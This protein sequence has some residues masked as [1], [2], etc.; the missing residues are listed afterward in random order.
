MEFEKKALDMYGEVIINKSLVQKA[1]FSARS[2]PTYVGEWI[3]FN[4]IEDGILT[5][6]SRVKVSNFIDRFLPQKGE[7]EEVKNRLINMEPVKLLDDYSVSINLQSGTRYLRIPFLDINDAIVSQKIIEDNNLLLGSG[8]WGVGELFYVPPENEK[9][10]GSVLMR[11]FKPFQI[12]AVDIDYFI[13][14]RKHFG[15]DEWLDLIISSMG[16]NPTIYSLEQKFVLITRIVAFVEPRINLI[17]LAPKGTGKSFVYDNF[18]RYARVVR[19]G[20]ITPAVMFF[21]HVRNTPGLISKYDTVVLDEIQSIQT[22]SELSAGLKTYLESGKFSRGDTEATSEA[23]FVMLGN[24]P[25]DKNRNPLNLDK[26]LLKDFPNFLQETAFLDRLHGI[27]PGWYMP[28][29]TSETPSQM[30]GFKGDFL[31]EVLHV[32]RGRSDFSDYVAGNMKLKNCKD[33]RDTK[34]I[35]RLA[36]G[37]LKILF[38]DIS[39]TKK[40]FLEYC[41]KP[42]IELRQRVRDE[43]HKMDPEYKKIKIGYE[44]DY[45]NND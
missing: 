13:E 35:Q 20:K 22:D 43:L 8:V 37:F 38:P 1:G 18:S 36:T 25:L 32:L 4:F 11:N 26:G 23:G 9:D 42:A 30:M 17:E 24:I 7:K 44:E 31:S 10:K 6:E 2:I 5:N 41:L 45:Y 40:E 19:G 21:H 33:L 29:V 34:A 28:R 12:G 27:I 15:L 39:L 14:C 3:L 16:F